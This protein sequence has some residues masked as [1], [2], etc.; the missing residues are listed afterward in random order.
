MFDFLAKCV[1]GAA[2]CFILHTGVF[3]FRIQITQNAAGIVH[4]AKPQTDFQF[5]L[6]AG[7]FQELFRLICLDFQRTDT[8]FQ[9]LQNIV[10][11]IQVVL[12]L[13]QA[14]FCLVFLVAILGNTGRLVKNLTAIV[15]ARGND[16]VNTSLTDNGVTIATQTR[17]HKQHTDI[18]KTHRGTIELVLT[19]AGAIAPTGNTHLIRIH[20]QHTSGIVDD[21]GHL[22]IAHRTTLS[23]TIENNVLHLGSTQRLAGLFTQHPFDGITDIGLTATVGTHNGGHTIAEVQYGFIRKGFKSMQFQCF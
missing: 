19:A 12:R 1:D 13:T 15:G 16:F 7:V 22:C 11:T 21:Q 3:Q 17:I 8:V 18:L 4:G 5:L 14:I 2:G 9:L 6:L 23:G 20:F 10:Q